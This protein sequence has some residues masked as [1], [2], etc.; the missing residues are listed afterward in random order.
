MPGPIMMGPPTKPQLDAAKQK[1]VKE[2]AEAIVKVLKGVPIADVGPI[3]N[4]A[5]QTIMNK[6]KV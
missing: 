1:I 2:K 3:F 5:T 6:T 4:E